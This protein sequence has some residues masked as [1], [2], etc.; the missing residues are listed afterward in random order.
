MRIAMTERTPVVIHVPV[1]S[2]KAFCCSFLKK[3]ET[4]YF[5]RAYTPVLVAD[6]TS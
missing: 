4:T 5:I 3:P 6:K 1:I 2:V